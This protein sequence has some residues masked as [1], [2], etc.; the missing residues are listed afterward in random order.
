M[1]TH[2]HTIT[3]PALFLQ[4]TA[5]PLMTP[6][7]SRYVTL[8]PRAQLIYLPGLNHVPISDDPTAVAHHMLT[9]LDQIA[10]RVV[11]AN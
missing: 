2:L 1:P 3:A 11:T 7:I 10:P 5:D 9:F 4:G 8:I 6:Q